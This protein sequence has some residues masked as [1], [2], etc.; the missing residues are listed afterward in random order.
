MN[1]NRITVNFAINVIG[2]ALPIVVSLVTVPIYI[3]YIG[4]AR[5]G[6]LSIVWLLVGYLSFLDF[7]IAQSASRAL[8]ERSSA[9]REERA[10]FLLTAFYF[11]LTLGMLG[12]VAVYFIGPLFLHRLLTLT[13]TLGTEIDAAFLWIAAI[14]PVALLAATARGA[15]DSR[16]RFLAANI[17]D[18]IGTVLW[19]ILP[20]LCAFT[21]GPSLTVLIAAA[22]VARALGTV[23]ALGFVAWTE[24]LTTLRVFDYARVK[25]LLSFG[26]WLS[27]TNIISPLLMAIDQ[28]L[29]GSMLGVTAVAHYAVPMSL[30]VRSQIVAAGLQRALFPR[31]ARLPAGEAAALAKRAALSLAYCLGAICGPAIIVAGPFLTWW[32]GAAFAGPATP[33][34]QLLLLG[35]WVNGVAY[36]PHALLQAQGRPDLVAKLHAV[37]IVPFIAVLW[38]LLHQ[39]GLP[40][41]A[42][43]W[44]GRVTFD[45]LFLM[46]LAQF[47][48]VHLIRLLPPF[49]LVV[50]AYV[51]VSL[52]EMQPLMSVLVAGLSFLACVGGALAFD[53]TLRNLLVALYAR[54][55]EARA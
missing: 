51:T 52:A 37:E 4:P 36:I 34:M 10:Q 23:S 54:V 38:V 31:F 25:K 55:G 33:V 9:A 53:G 3:S 18:L 15:I 22:F 7:G 24:R 20:I 50:A 26:V 1:A 46:K 19:Q 21:F 13:D 11:N 41:A 2:M 35:A 42:L 27:V 44:T 39:F 16:E 29:V 28:L 45:A 43:A 48:A 32:T 6:V 8:A 40:G 12:G 17:F 47:R 14:I 30:V 5:Y 49:A